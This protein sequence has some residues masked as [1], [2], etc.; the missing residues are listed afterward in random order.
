M[1]PIDIALAIGVGALFYYNREFFWYRHDHKAAGKIMALL[2]ISGVLFATFFFL[3]AVH[4]IW[5]WAPYS[6]A[7]PIFPFF[8]TWVLA[9]VYALIAAIAW[10]FPISR[11][12]NK[13]EEMHP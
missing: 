9:G 13:I 12:F 4:H 7:V 10:M 8:Y 3:F 1:L 11:A 5:T 6:I 2:E